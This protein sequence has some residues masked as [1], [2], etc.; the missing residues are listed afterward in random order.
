MNQRLYTWTP[1]LLGNQFTLARYRVVTADLFAH[2]SFP[3]S[4]RLFGYLRRAIFDF[5]CSTWASSLE[6]DKYES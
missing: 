3:M 4:T 2:T 5:G 1:L 6:P